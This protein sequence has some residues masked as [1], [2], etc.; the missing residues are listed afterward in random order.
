VK[1]ISLIPARGGSKGIPKK[2]LSVIAGTTL[3]GLKVAQAQLS[4][5]N[6][7]WVSTDNLEIKEE[8]RNEGARVLDRPEYL[9]T[10]EA[11]TDSML[12]HAIENIPCGPDDIIV[13][14]QITSPL[15]EIDSINAC[16]SKLIED[17]SLNS[18]ITVRESHPFM[19]ITKDG[20]NWEPSG[21]TRDWRPRRQDLDRGGWETGGCY[22]IRV[23][24]I[25]TQE[26][27]YPAPTGTIN[28]SFLESIDIDTFQDLEVARRVLEKE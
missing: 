3:L 4:L 2:N 16:I 23:S 19:W 27:R 10:D 28:V 1:I 21:H 24:A 17:K 9:S 22:A 13:L 15:L 25:R 6:E 7:I 12:I 26:V 14:L 20:S 8:A 5:S 18:V 11:S